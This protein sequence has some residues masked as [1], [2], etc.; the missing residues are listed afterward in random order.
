[1]AL[2]GV[3]TPKLT[4]LC[5][6]TG[7]AFGIKCVLNPVFQKQIWDSEIFMQEAYWS[8]L[9]G[10][11]CWKGEGSRMVRGKVEPWHNRKGRHSQPQWRLWSLKWSFTIVLNWVRQCSQCF[12][13]PPG[14]VI[15]CGRP[16]Q[17]KHTLGQSSFLWLRASIRRTSAGNGQ[18]PSS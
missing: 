12:V 10:A 13:A 7:S 15:K 8:M 3:I 17:K 18:Q 4:S 16:L 1:M 2:E 9:S 11:Q 6:I 14:P 5:M